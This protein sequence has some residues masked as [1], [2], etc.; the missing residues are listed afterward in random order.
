MN[1]DEITD[2]LP[3]RDAIRRELEHLAGK[4]PSRRELR[5]RVSELPGAAQRWLPRRHEPVWTDAIT[6]RSLAVFGVGMALGA[7]LAALLSPQSGPALR[8]ELIERVQRLRETTGLGGASAGES[9]SADRASRD[10][11][12][13]AGTRP[14]FSH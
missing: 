11:G 14:D 10:D 7:G 1:I 4:L 9:P 2:R 12:N 13:G 3:D 8:R 5:A 6:A